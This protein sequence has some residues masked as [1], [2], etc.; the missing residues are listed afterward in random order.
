MGR[1]SQ[2]DTADID[3]AKAGLREQA[4][5]QRAALRSSERADHAEAAAEHFF[6]H[7]K[8]SAAQR[9]GAYW[10][11][12]DEIDSRPVLVRLMDSGQPVL[13]PVVEGDQVPLTFRH[14]EEGAQLFEAGF[15]TLAPSETAPAWAPDVL[16]IPLLGFDK[17]GT[18]LGYGKGHYDR[19][20]ALLEKRPLVI[21]YAFSAQ[22]L[23]EI[24]RAEH[25]MPMDMLV[26]ENGVRTFRS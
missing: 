24:P 10:P 18:R 12:R 26:T 1:G 9:V 16:V 7:V 5:S 21:G 3:A 4:L 20:I 19:T 8:L 25:D 23:D 22:E 14:W 11:I 17:Y 13:L 2:V 15:G 6:A